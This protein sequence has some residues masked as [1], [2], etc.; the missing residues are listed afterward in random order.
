M[1]ACFVS[2]ISNSAACLLPGRQR[3]RAHGRFQVVAENTEVEA[4]LALGNYDGTGH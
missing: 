1:V 4:S 2:F 3:N